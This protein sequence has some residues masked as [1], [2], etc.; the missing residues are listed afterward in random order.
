MRPP[1]AHQ[2]EDRAALGKQV[3]VNLADLR[4]R[5]VVD[6]SDEARD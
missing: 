2:I 1:T 3:R 5:A 6:M 4:D